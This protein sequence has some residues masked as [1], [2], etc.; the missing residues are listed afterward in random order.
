MNQNILLLLAVLEQKY[1]YSERHSGHGP[2][3]GDNVVVAIIE[4]NYLSCQQTRRQDMDLRG[5]KIEN[6]SI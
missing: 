4:V 6:Q 3:E 2:E 1:K 5:W